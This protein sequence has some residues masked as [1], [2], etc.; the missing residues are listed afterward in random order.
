MDAIYQQIIAGK[1]K[2]VV[3]FILLFL[4][5]FFAQHGIDITQMTVGQAI[6]S[7]I[8]GLIGYAGV[9]IKRNQA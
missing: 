7:L 3:G 8:Y 1:Q 4:G 2:A 6:E 9:Y 5:S